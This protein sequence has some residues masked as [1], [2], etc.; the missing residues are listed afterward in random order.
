MQ[1]TFARTLHRTLLALILAA[2]ALSP[3]ASAE[4]YILPEDRE[5]IDQAAAI[6]V[7][8][9]TSMHTAFDPDETIVTNVDLEVETV[10]KG[11]LDRS[12]ALRLVEPGGEIGTQVVLVSAAPVYW[13]GNRALIFLTRTEDGDWRTWGAALG[14]FDFVKDNR[15]RGLLV[16]WIGHSGHVELWSPGATPVEDQVRD[17]ARFLAYIAR[18]APRPTPVVPVSPGGPTP[19]EQNPASP[20][21]NAEADYFVEN[22]EGPV[23]NPFAWD[24]ATNATYPP[25]AYTLGTFRWDDFDEGKFVTFHVSGSQPGYDSI[26]AA[27]RALAAWTNDSG[28]NVDYRYGGTSTAP[29][30]QDSKNTIVYNS[31]SDVPSGAIAYARW[32]AAGSHTYKSETFYTIV[33]GDVVVK[34]NLSTSQKSFEEAVTHELGHTLGFRH[35]DQGTPSSTQAVMKAVLTGNYGATLGPWDVEAVRTV[36]ESTGTGPLT[37]RP[38]VSF[39]DDPLQPGMTIKA[40]HLIE[41]RNAINAAR[42][43]AGLAAVGWTDPAP[44]GKTVKAVHVNEMRE[45]IAPV[46]PL[47]GETA[48]YSNAV[49]APGEVI[50]AADFQELRDKL[51]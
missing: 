24:P 3:I 11:D 45:A 28:S 47:M 10:L 2:L 16:R 23:S 50:R 30:V 49:I 33:E 22:P 38:S 18:E 13:V 20:E 31:S 26:G 15:G 4:L 17:A 32:Y 29:F 25:S 48:V 35:S 41:L 9:V 46:L 12:E 39:T 14:K 5:M 6:V 51:R 19:A 7:A 42:Q 27:Q 36:Y 21:Q 40:V 34:S 1:I 37:P 43:W 8:K 44:Q